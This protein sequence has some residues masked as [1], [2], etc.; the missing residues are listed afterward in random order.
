MAVAECSATAGLSLGEYAA[1]VFAGVM[2]FEDGL[3][4]LAMY[5]CTHIT[6]TCHLIPLPVPRPLCT[7]LD[8]SNPLMYV[9]GRVYT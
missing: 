8:F 3:K 6:S 7:Y 5:A 9:P 1:L 2:S 4:V